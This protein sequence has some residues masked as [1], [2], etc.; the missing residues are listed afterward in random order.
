LEASLIKIPGIF[1]KNPIL[2][3]YVLNAFKLAP[4]EYR[5]LIFSTLVV[6]LA[7]P[8]RLK[9]VIALDKFIHLSLANWL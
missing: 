2:Y 6:I 7:I 9:V 8:F 4:N 5:I 1:I 3:F